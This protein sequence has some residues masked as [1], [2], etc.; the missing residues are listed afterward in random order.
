MT[1]PDRR[2]KQDLPALVHAVQAILRSWDPIG[3]FVMDPGW[4]ADEY[5]SYAPQIV[6]MLAEGASVESVTKH[7]EH[8]RTKTM[9]LPANREADTACAR[10]LLAWWK[11]RSESA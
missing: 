2:W 11:E 5:D 8:L 7:L 10:R 1:A 4:P 6:G 9:A 3:V